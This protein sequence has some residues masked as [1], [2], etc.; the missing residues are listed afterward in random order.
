MLLTTKINNAFTPKNTQFLFREKLF[1]K[2]FYP[3]TQHINN[4]YKKILTTRFDLP[5]NF[6]NYNL[7]ENIKVQTLSKMLE[8]FK[9]YIKVQSPSFENAI[10]TFTILFDF[11]DNIVCEPENRN[12]LLKDLLNIKPSFA[13]V[14]KKYISDMEINNLFFYQFPHEKISNNFY[15][16]NNNNQIPIN[17]STPKQIIHKAICD[18]FIQKDKNLQKVKTNLLRQQD[19]AKK[20]NTLLLLTLP[21]HDYNKAFGKVFITELNYLEKN[22]NIDIYFPFS[23]S[24]INKIFKEKQYDIVMFAC[25]GTPNKLAFSDFFII[26]NY[27]ASFLDFPNLS[28]K[29]VIILNSCYAGAIG[30]IAETIFDQSNKKVIAPFKDAY[31]GCFW[32]TASLIILPPT[33]EKTKNFLFSHIFLNH[34]GENITRVFTPKES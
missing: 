22:S 9:T 16:L 10:I 13:T 28:S 2:K 29:A 17:A 31:S 21:F 23:I 14:L 11:I 24:H 26:D 5:K 33:Y 12:F 7:P 15:L 32:N 19:S 3:Q 25:H 6:N 20:I 4:L 18:T 8:F 27:T 1:K 34:L 30:G